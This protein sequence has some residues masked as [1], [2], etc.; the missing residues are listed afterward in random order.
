MLFKFQQDR[1]NIQSIELSTEFQKTT[2]MDLLLVNGIQFA[3]FIEG[4]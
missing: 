2:N 3:T 1:V 4:K